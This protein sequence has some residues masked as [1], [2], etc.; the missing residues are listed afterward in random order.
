MDNPAVVYGSETWPV[1]DINRRKVS[2][3]ERKN[4][5]K[6]MFTIGRTSNM[7]NKI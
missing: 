5:L 7:E 3:W 6:Y 4:I 2:T 1:T